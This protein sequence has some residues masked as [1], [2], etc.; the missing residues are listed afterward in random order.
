MLPSC[1]LSKKI[2]ELMRR[3]D[4]RAI[5]REDNII[6]GIAFFSRILRPALQIGIDM[7]RTGHQMDCSSAKHFARYG[8]H[9]N[10]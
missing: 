2:G 5:Y 6:L 10:Q 7:A 9:T 1:N 4:I 8:D 3:W